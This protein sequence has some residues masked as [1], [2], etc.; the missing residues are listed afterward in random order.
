MPNAER[1][2]DCPS[3]YRMAWPVIILQ[4]AWFGSVAISRIWFSRGIVQPGA[5]SWLVAI[6]PSILAVFVL[7][8]YV[9]YVRALDELWI[10]IYSR[11][12]ALSFGVSV[13][14]LFTY[15]IFELAGAPELNAF[16]YGAFS[17]IVFCGAA[18]LC[19]RRYR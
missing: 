6:V 7:R 15:P 12:L 4:L 13:L 3:H 11:A 18:T 9:G 10:K 14:F 2:N 1:V 16:G 8:A 19:Y 17:V 5:Y